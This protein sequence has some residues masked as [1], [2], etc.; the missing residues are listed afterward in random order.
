MGVCGKRHG[1]AALPPGLV[2]TGVKN[3]PPTGI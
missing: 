2:W 1:P 3:P